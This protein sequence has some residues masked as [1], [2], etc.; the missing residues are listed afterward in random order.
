VAVSCT[1]CSNP[2]G[3]VLPVHETA[4]YRCDDTRGCITQFWPPDDEHM[5]SKHVEAW[6]KLTVKQKICASSW[7]ITEI[8]SFSSFV[9]MSFTNILFFYICPKLLDYW[10]ILYFTV[11]ANSVKSL[12]CCNFCSLRERQLIFLFYWRYSPSW[13]LASS[14][15]ALHWSQS[16]YCRP[17]FL[18]PIIFRT[19]FIE[20]SHKLAG[21]STRAIALYLIEC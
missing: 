8:K 10:S 4:T 15:I 6:T 21:L 12:R 17:K 16:C 13:K 9:D 11:I 3:F 20:S 7:L 19:S 14:N 5:C 2:A 1:G 18:K